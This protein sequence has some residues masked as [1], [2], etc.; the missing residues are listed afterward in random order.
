METIQVE[1]AEMNGPLE[2]YKSMR[3]TFQSIFSDETKLQYLGDVIWESTFAPDEIQHEVGPSPVKKP[4]HRKI[5]SLLSRVYGVPIYCYRFDQYASD[6]ELFVKN[7]E[8][9]WKSVGSISSL[10]IPLLKSYA[11]P[12]PFGDLD[13][14][15]TAYDKTVRDAWEITEFK[16]GN[17]NATNLPD[18]VTK[19][20]LFQIK[21]TWKIENINLV[22]QKINIYDKGGFFKPHTDTPTHPGRTIG[23]LVVYLCSKFSG[24]EFTISHNNQQQNLNDFNKARITNYW[25]KWIAFYSDCIHQVLPVKSGTRVTV[26]YSIDVTD[27]S[28]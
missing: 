20:I 27:E 21:A 11:K 2:T 1:N 7:V 10:K 6:M 26:T 15:E 9:E 25:V 13:K 18:F 14:M 8:D 28:E 4:S 22:P 24:G 16:F 5:N 17:V 19:D 12:S 23:S 3:K